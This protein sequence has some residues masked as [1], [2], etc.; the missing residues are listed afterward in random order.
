MIVLDASVLIGHLEGTD[1]HHDQADR[2]LARAI[3]ANEAL[4]A[5]PLTLAEVLVGPTRSGRLGRA[6]VVLGRLGLTRT[7]MPDEAPAR[8]ARLRVETGLKL[9]DCCVLLAAEQIAGK[10][11]TFDV[12]LARAATQRGMLVTPL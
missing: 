10:V 11:A 8:L 3:R 2:L 1:A 5:S 6:E 12:H 9:P 7:T 4:T